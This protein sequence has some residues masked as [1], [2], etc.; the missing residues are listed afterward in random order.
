VNLPLGKYAST[1][2]PAAIS[3]LI[4]GWIAG[5]VIQ[6]RIERPKE[7]GESSVLIFGPSKDPQLAARGRE[8]KSLLGIK[9]DLRILAR[10]ED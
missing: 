9:P 1:R 8:L 3:R 5:V 6:I 2:F 7:G 10:S 4:R